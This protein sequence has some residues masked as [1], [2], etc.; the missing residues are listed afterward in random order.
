MVG[1][2]GAWRWGGRE[3]GAYL[4]QRII[5]LTTGGG[6]ATGRNLRLTWAVGLSWGH[7]HRMNGRETGLGTEI[8]GWFWTL[9]SLVMG[10]AF[11]VTSAG[12][13]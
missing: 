2:A 5:S 12:R 9:L 8:G 6:L 10:R 13:K 4:G 3:Q 11:E 7:T 1:R